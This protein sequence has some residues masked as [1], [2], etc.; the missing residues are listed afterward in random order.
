VEPQQATEELR[1][2]LQE[3]ARLH[4]LLQGTREEATTGDGKGP[5]GTRLPA[6]KS[7]LVISI[8]QDLRQPLTSILGYTD[9]LLGESVGTLGDLQRSYLER[10]HNS[11]ERMNQLIGNLVQIAELD[12]PRMKASGEMLH[13]ADL[14]EN[15]L[16]Q[17]HDQIKQK[18]I[19]LQ[20]DVAPE[21]PEMEINRDALEQVVFHLLENA[22]AATP[23]GGQVA[24]RAS[25]GDETAAGGFILIQ[26]ADAGGGIREEDLPHVFSRVYRSSNPLIQGV[27]DTGVGLSIAEALSKALGGKIWVDS[28][29]GLGATFSLV[30]PVK[31]PNA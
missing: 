24:L 3:V 15:V 2:A 19:D 16:G 6:E 4:A 25:E 31:H 21:L 5:N 23:E 7:E 27:G 14:I 20:L 13:I 26:I 11:T 22:M 30:L 18:G 12:T 29:S 28:Q 9:L 10:V 1:L 17:V 8:A